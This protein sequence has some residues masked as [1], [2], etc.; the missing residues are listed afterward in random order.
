M[1]V[2]SYHI[3]ISEKKMV[4]AN[5][6]E[7]I[8]VPEGVTPSVNEG[9]LTMKGEKGEI[10]RSFIY[11]GV[12]LSIADDGITFSIEKMTKNEKKVVR[13]FAAHVRNMIKGVTAGH[14]YKLK[15]CSGHFPM[16]VSV[17]NNALEVKNFIGE[18]VPRSLKFKE[19]VNVDVNGDMISVKGISKELVSQTAASIESLTRRNGFDRRVFQDGIYIVDKDG[20]V[21]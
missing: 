16:N 12:V 10:S 11:P 15:I 21:I 7:T 3:V 18:K 8:A 1:V 13:T 9:V 20:K 14:E 6:T 4:Q 19:G 5:V 2:D 17:K